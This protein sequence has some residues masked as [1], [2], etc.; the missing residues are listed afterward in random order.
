MYKDAYHPRVKQDLKKLHARL[1]ATIKTEHI[2][3][4][5]AHPE[6]GEVL[7]GDL[8][9]I[10]SYHLTFANQQYRIAYVIDEQAEIVSALMIAKRGEF[11][12]L[13]KRRMRR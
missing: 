6:I 12:Q 1:R 8:R 11:Y 4:I 3:E 13:L 7:V 10:W 2:P 9:G 5:L